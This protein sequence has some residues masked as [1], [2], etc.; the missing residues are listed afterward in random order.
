V[1]HLSLSIA[2]ENGESE[3]I[4]WK[5]FE[6]WMKSELHLGTFNKRLA[7]AF[8]SY[9]SKVNLYFDSVVF[10]LGFHNPCTPTKNI[11]QE[12]SR[13]IAAL[14]AVRTQRI[15]GSL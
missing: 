7:P 14:K 9:K 13:K 1:L 4:A 11:D 12:I 10:N 2:F 8:N 3:E 5:R 15:N 6:S